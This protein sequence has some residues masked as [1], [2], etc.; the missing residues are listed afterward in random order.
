VITVDRASADHHRQRDPGV[1]SQRRTVKLLLCAPT[2]RAAKRLKRDQQG[3]RPKP[4]H[5]LL[6]SIQGRGFKRNVENPLDCDLL[7]LDETSDG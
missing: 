3:K 4:S 7:V 2:G 5:R 1:F 6:E